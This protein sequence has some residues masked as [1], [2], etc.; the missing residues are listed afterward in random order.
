MSLN[1]SLIKA[2]K[3]QQF[4]IRYSGPLRISTFSIHL[5]HHHSISTIDTVSTHCPTFRHGLSVWAPTIVNPFPG[6]YLPP[7]ANAIRQDWF[8][9]RKNCLEEK[10]VISTKT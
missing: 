9:A 4:K 2:I 1:Q 7:T 10:N 3:S 5:L 6:L 8:L